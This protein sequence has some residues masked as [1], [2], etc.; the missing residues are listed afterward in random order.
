MNRVREKRKPSHD[1]R[2]DMAKGHLG[3]AGE[4]LRLYDPAASQWLTTPEE[5]AVKAEE[6][7]SLAES[8]RD[9]ERA[10]RLKAE[11]ELARLRREIGHPRRGNSK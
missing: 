5:R 1:T 7:R 6:G 10:A 11:T 2:I 3:A 4:E 9:Q 8:E